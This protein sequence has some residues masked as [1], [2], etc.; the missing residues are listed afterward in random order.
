MKK[1]TLLGLILTAILGVL[2]VFIAFQS[3][4]MANDTPFYSV[5]IHIEDS[6][7]QGLTGEKEV[8]ATLRAFLM[9]NRDSSALGINAFLLETSLKALPY[10]QDAQ[11]YWNMDSSLMIDIVNKQAVAMALAPS[12]NRFITANNEV[13]PQPQNK[14]LDLPIITGAADSLELSRSGALLARI[15]ELFSEENIAQ[16]HLNETQVEL[17]P[18]AYKHRITAHSDGR[19]DV[20]LEKLAAY[21]AAH[22]EED[23]EKVKTIDLRFKNQ[24]VTT[25]R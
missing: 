19:I 5:Q 16:L 7:K 13:L 9:E 20:E 17:T 18:S 12:G 8:R 11:V 21:Y 4:N 23:L 15:A 1:R 2:L 24:V 10:V 3:Q 14:W 6:E 22:T 25:E